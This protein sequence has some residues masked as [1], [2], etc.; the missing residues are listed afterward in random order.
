MSFE[1]ISLHLPIK[2][3]R[4]Y[5]A[6]HVVIQATLLGIYFAIV[7]DLLKVTQEIEKDH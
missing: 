7:I 5:R 2:C 3:L 1:R 6:A 4:I